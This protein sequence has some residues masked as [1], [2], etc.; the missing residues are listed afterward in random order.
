MTVNRRLDLAESLLAK[1]RS[2][3]YPDERLSFAEGALG[4]LDA[5]LRAAG[6]GA[7]VPRG[8]VIEPSVVDRPVIDLRDD[9]VR[10]PIPPVPPASHTTAPPTAAPASVADPRIEQARRAYGTTLRPPAAGRR[11]D[12]SL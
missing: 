10:P 4:Q 5:F 8:E 7:S 6:V 2:T 11:L 9:P 12:L 1:A 3:S